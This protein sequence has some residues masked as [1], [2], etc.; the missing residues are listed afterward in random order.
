M[1]TEYQT[2]LNF[3]PSC[4]PPFLPHLR[5]A[6]PMQ[7]VRHLEI[8]R[9]LSTYTLIK[10]LQTLYPDSPLIKDIILQAE[11]AM[12]TMTTNLI[13]GLRTQ[14]I[15]LAAAMRT[16]GWLRR[17]APKL[18]DPRRG[19]ETGTGSGE[20]SLGALF[21]VCRLANLVS[22]LEA[23]DPL[24]ELADQETQRRGEAAAGERAASKWSGGQQTERYL[25]R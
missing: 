13:A 12:K 8:T 20:G 5:V 2:S 11:D 6:D 25:K 21:L 22:T 1:S 4:R 23:L 3:Q 9:Q 16:I 14:N 24:R 19:H 18:E 10:R 17:V 15:R 7:Q